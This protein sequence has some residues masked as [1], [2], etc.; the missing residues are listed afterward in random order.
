MSTVKIIFAGP[1]G[2]GKTTAIAAI[3]DITPFTTEEFATDEVRDIKSK[4]TVAM[5]YGMMKLD[6]GERIHLYG[7]PG[8]ER[9]NFMWEILADGAIGLVLLLRNSN[10]DPL[11]DLK[12]YLDNF[13]DLIKKT[14]VAIGVTHIEENRKISLD[15]YVKVL[16]E[17]N[18]IAPVFEIDGR[19]KNDIITL[20][21]ALLFTLDPGLT[22]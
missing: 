6:S 14:G 15:D 18:I 4:T 13:K 16:H 22:H 9:F 21:Q 17:R 2:A 1:V 20:T 5:D 19:N 12:T 11:A 3:S 10:D 7:T 8:Q